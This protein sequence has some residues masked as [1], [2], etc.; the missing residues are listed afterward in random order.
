MSVT[1]ARSF[2]ASGV[3]AGIRYSRPDLAIV[4][5]A[6]PAVGAAMWSRNRVQAACLQVSREHMELAE[7]QAVVVNS[8]VANSATGER[9]K[10]DALATAAEA[11]RLLDLDLE[12][13][14]VLST[15][16][17]GVPLPMDRLLPGL[18]AAA[19]ALDPEGGAD[20]AGAIMTTDTR[21]KQAVA[22]G[23]GFAEELEEI[24][25]ILHDRAHDLRDGRQTPPGLPFRQ[26]S[27]GEAPDAR[28]TACVR[29]KGGQQ[30]RF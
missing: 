3:H 21:P 22:T 6:A 26:S 13:V 10:L 17:I 4:R 9:G 8:G 11:G 14:L 7:P 28:I 20:A 12:Q 19:D 2:V 27:A 30:A 25:L 18:R 24:A 15:G 5:S 23:P 1:A 16:V 29:H